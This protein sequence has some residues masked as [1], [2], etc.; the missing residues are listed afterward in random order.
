MKS[1]CLI[2]FTLYLCFSVKA[3]FGPQQIIDADVYGISKIITAD[4]N[5]DGFPD[6]ITSQKYFNN[7]RISYFLNTGQ[8]S[9][10]P[11]NILTT[12]VITPEGVASGDLDGDGWTDIVGISQVSNSVYW[13]PNNNGSF[14]LEIPLDSTLIMPE[15]VE[16]VDIDNDGH[17]DIVVLDHTNIV[18]YYNDGSANFTK[19]TVPN[20][21]FEYYAF[22]V[23]DIDGDG[24]H[25][26]VI[27]SGE[28]LVYMNVNG[29][30]ST[31][32]VARTAS[33]VNPGLIFLV[34]A[35]DLDGDGNM[36]LIIDGNGNSDI[37][38]YANDGNGFFS[39]MQ[40]IENTH[41]CKS[42][43]TA[44]FDNDGDM[45]VFAALFQEGEVGW[46][47]NTG[48]GIFNSQQLVSNGTPPNTIATAT[49]DLNNDGAID[50][51]WAH[52][53]SFQLNTHTLSVNNYGSSLAIHVYPNPV[54]DNLKVEASIPASLTI[55]DVMGKTL[56]DNY[57][58]EKGVSELV[59]PPARQVY[60][61]RFTSANGVVVKR[62][63]K[64]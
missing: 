8:A 19:V 39:F 11:Q 48:Q 13:F 54:R 23:T 63:V 21:Q 37:R 3:Q 14:P 46:Y 59:L 53:F 34:H 43:S 58:I 15:D 44:D 16:I 10:E 31:H 56:M 41:Q 36:D 17:P 38:W 32:D 40:T 35:A 55:F 45:D 1:L 61:L 25:D 24:F 5:N 4:L 30:F 49:A 20:D 18:I 26:I 57:P 9:F 28:A 42:L 6:I 27:G 50:V 12:N 64:E 29:Q 62:V 51:I 22:A 33:V 60:Y 47:E 2:F 52:P 7:H